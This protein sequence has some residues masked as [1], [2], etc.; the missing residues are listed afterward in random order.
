MFENVD[1]VHGWKL[2]F[3]ISG[4]L[5]LAGVVAIALGGLNLG[6]DFQGGAQFTVANASTNLTGVTT[7]GGRERRARGIVEAAGVHGEHINQVVYGQIA[8]HVIACTRT[9]TNS[10][11]KANV[12]APRDG[13]F[14]LTT[15]NSPTCSPLRASKSRPNGSHTAYRTMRLVRKRRNAASSDFAGSIPASFS[16]IASHALSTAEHALAVVAEPAAIGPGG[17]AESPRFT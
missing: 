5:L 6:I 1:F 17:R 7:E 3:S 16:L 13:S 9:S 8:D 12:S 10:A 15:L 11:P 2:Y 14:P 4:V